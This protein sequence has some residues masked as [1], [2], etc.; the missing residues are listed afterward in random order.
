MWPQRDPREIIFLCLCPRCCD[1]YFYFGQSV[2]EI[3]KGVV[4]KVDYFRVKQM[5]QWNFNK[6]S[7]K[8]SHFGSGKRASGGLKVRC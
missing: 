6:S 5:M 8:L 3:L 2:H 1:G 7:V 4:A